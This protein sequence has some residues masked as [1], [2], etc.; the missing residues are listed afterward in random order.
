[1]RDVEVLENGINDL[2]CMVGFEISVISIPL[3]LR[4]MLKTM[5]R[6]S[7]KGGL[8]DKRSQVEVVRHQDGSWHVS[9]VGKF[10][11]APSFRGQGELYEKIS[12]LCVTQDRTDIVARSDPS[13]DLERFGLGLG[14]EEIIELFVG[15]DSVLQLA[16]LPFQGL[17]VCF[18]WGRSIST[19]CPMS[20][21]ETTSWAFSV[22]LGTH[23]DK[24]RLVSLCIHSHRYSYCELVTGNTPS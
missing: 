1:M 24:T 17:R 12:I 23:K 13:Q 21:T 14:F 20:H 22:T 19:I 3:T 10:V 2:S 6:R 15:G 18:F 4:L 8:V 5:R 7:T 9:D 11:S 16:M